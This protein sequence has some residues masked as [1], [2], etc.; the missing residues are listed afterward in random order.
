MPTGV[1]RRASFEIRLLAPDLTDGLADFFRRLVE[2]DTE[3][4]FHPH[5]LDRGEAE[6][7]CNYLG[8]DEYFAVMS[9]GRVIGYCF[10][11][12]WDDGF[13]APALG[14]A[15]DNEFQGRGIGRCV[16]NFLHTV[17]RLRGAE[18]IRLK[19]YP[20]NGKALRLYR[21][22]GY[23]FEGEEKAQM[24]GNIELACDN[25]GAAP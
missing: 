22:L 23:I 16:M 8:E 21:S 17:A 19:V 25:S 1:D 11:R 6:R 10:L 3:R 12:G 20:E 24:V 15:I 18:R 2:S 7:R 13:V 14:I 9:R 4:F 5:G